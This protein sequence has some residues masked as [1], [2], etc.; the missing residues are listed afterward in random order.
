MFKGFK[1]AMGPELWWG[2]NP[3]ILLKYSKTFGKI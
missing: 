2:A 3:A 1:L